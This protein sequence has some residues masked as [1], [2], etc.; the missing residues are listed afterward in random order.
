MQII[1]PMAGLGER[2]KFAGYK[3]PKPLIPIDG[4]PVI[5]HI[6]NLF[7]PEDTFLFICNENHLRDTNMKEEILRIRPDAKIVSIKEHYLGPVYTTMQAKEFI[8]DDEP[9]LTCYCDINVDWDYNHFKT[10]MKEREADSAVIAFKGFHPP[11]LQEGFYATARVNENNEVLEVREKHSFT[12]NKM[13]SWTSAGMHYFRRGEFIKKYFEQM[14]E[15]QMLCN[16]EYYISLSHNLLIEAGL[17]NVIYP[18]DYFISWGKPADVQEYQYWSKHF[19]KIDD[20][21][22]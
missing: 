10:Q 1:I 13:D 12:P 4:K 6:V 8:R 7:A 22:N 20:D 17:K 11:L 14:M 5:E 3:D 19:N 21:K 2:F 18:V 15:R 9:A 16:K